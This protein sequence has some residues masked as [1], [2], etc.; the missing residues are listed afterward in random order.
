MSTN[1]NILILKLQTRLNC[2]L[3][4]ESRRWAGCSSQ[5]TSEG[6]VSSH[7]AYAFEPRISARKSREIRALIL[8][9]AKE[10]VPDALI[11]LLV[12]LQQRMMK[13]KEAVFQSLCI[14]TQFLIDRRFNSN[15]PTTEA[16]LG[17]LGYTERSYQG[18]DLRLAS[19]VLQRSGLKIRALQRSKVRRTSLP[20][21][22]KERAEPAHTWM[23]SWEKQYQPSPA[24]FEEEEPHI[25]ELLSPSEVAFHFGR[26]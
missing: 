18:N 13:K 11:P 14:A 8:V 16:I 22:P 5:E 1:V 15:C 20:R 19:D 9:L 2:F 21:R 7:T 6:E 3:R 4:E 12:E 26:R 23:P 24:D 17:V 10:G 25:C